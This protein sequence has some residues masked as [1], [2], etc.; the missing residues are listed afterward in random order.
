[1]LKTATSGTGQCSEGRPNSQAAHRLS[2]ALQIQHAP[3]RG[4]REDGTTIDS[5][6]RLEGSHEANGPEGADKW[7][8]GML[9]RM[10]GYSGLF[11]G[12][13]TVYQSFILFAAQHAAGQVVLHEFQSFVEVRAYQ[14]R[15]SESVQLFEASIAT[16]FVVSCTHYATY[17]SSQC[18]SIP[19]FHHSVS[20]NCC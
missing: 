12:A 3:R 6:G 14:H 19:C 20:L 5:W 13:Q 16:D 11:D 17:H 8:V 1:M 10:M 4:H 9:C 7:F 15:V 18:F 2:S